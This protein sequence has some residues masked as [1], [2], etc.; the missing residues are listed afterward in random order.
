M[1]KTRVV[2]YLV[3]KTV[4]NKDAVAKATGMYW[5]RVLKVGYETTLSAFHP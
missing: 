4:D 5:R 2:S 1:N 3:F